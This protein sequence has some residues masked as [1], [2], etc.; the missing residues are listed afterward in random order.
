MIRRGGGVE[1]V[2]SCD[3]FGVFPPKS[4]LPRVGR[5]RLTWPF[6]GLI[7][8]FPLYQ[9]H[10]FEFNPLTPCLDGGGTANCEEIEV[11]YSHFA[12]F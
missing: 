12:L 5:S 1:G 6:L 10:R 2:V 11:R 9:A 7:S 3:S 4:F 8:E